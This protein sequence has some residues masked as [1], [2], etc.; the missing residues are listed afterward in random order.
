MNDSVFDPDWLVGMLTKTC[1]IGLAFIVL[2]QAE[3]GLGQI[4]GAN[5][6]QTK[7]AKHA[8]T[9]ILHYKLERSRS[10]LP[11]HPSKPCNQCVRPDIPLVFPK[12][13]Q[14]PGWRGRPE[15][16]G[17][18]GGCKCNQCCLSRNTPNISQF[19]PRPFTGLLDDCRTNTCNPRPRDIFDKF[20]DFKLIAYQRTDNGFTGNNGCGRNADPFG[21]LGES[22]FW[23]QAQP[24]F[25][26]ESNLPTKSINAAQRLG[27]QSNPRNRT[28]SRPAPSRYPARSGTKGYPL[29]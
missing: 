26:L 23:A 24:D 19:W 20:E 11:I 10:P 6:N 4:P 7:K 12:L 9:P 18:P 3:T 8:K 17:E 13:G 27:S 2:F 1:C 28:A 15:I 21:C 16:P 29:F 22:K 5:A 25:Y 14:I